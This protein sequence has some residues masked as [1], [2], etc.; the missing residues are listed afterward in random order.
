MDKTNIKF[1]DLL[2]E[3]VSEPGIVSAAYSQFYQYSL[4]NQI[5]A[6][7]ECKARNLTVGPIATYKKWQSL[8]RQVKKGEKAIALCMPITVPRKKAKAE[9]LDASN[10][11]FATIFVW[12]NNWFTL[13]QT[14]GEDYKQEETPVNFDLKN[15]ISE[16]EIE[17]I[18]FEETNGNVM[19]YAIKNT[20]AV[21]PLNKHAFKTSLHEIAHILLGHTD[22]GKVTDEERLSRAER[23]VEAESVAYIV[24]SI[25]G[26]DHL[27]ESRGYIQNWLGSTEISEKSAKKIFRVAEQILK[28]GRV[29]EE[30]IA[31]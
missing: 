8:G 12:R 31:A 26:D 9:D 20:F 25:V 23:E 22:K 10:K 7:F 1:S 4:G 14:E 2:K 18:S 6:Y 15:V 27:E 16:N 5:T 19:G 3:A 29:E 30:Q 11:E 21:N 17:Q 13:A 28:S 24:G